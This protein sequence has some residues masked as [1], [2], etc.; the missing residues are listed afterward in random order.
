MGEGTKDD[1]KPAAEIQQCRFIRQLALPSS[2][3][4]GINHH[5]LPAA[6]GGSGKSTTQLSHFTRT[7]MPLWPLV[8][9]TP[10]GLPNQLAEPEPCRPASPA[11][12]LLLLGLLLLCLAPR[13]A[14]AWK[15]G[16]LCPDGVFYIQLAK[17]IEQ[18][19]AVPAAQLP[20]YPYPMLLALC[21]AR[22]WIGNLPAPSGAC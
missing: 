12:P 10:T 16:G 4:F 20:L 11:S 7:R 3:T 13:A 19:H 21:I 18:G 17:S 8:Q 1:L 6:T 22:A 2:A 15:L 14:M 5:P 9:P